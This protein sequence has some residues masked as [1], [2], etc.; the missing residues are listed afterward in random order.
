MDSI[1][2]ISTLNFKNFNVGNKYK[3]IFIGFILSLIFRV[4]I[5]TPILYYFVLIIA[6]GVYFSVFIIPKKLLIYP[7]VIII[8]TMPDLT[9]STNELDVYG[10]IE[11]ANLWQFSIGSFT[12]AVLIFFMLLVV[13]I[14]LLPIPK[15]LPY[16]KILFYFILI[17]PIVSIYNGFLQN[18]LARFV[19]DF[20]IV[21]FFC[22]GLIIFHCYFNQF[23]TELGKITI[24]FVF[25]ALGTFIIDLIKFIFK[26]DNQ[27]IEQSYYNLS[28]DSAKGLITIFLF[29]ALTKLLKGKKI[30]INLIVILIVIVLLF[31][32][33]TRWLLVTLILGVLLM[34]S[35]NGF[36]KL[37]KILAI[38]ALV[39]S[40]VVP[41]L[42]E[43]NPEPW[44][45]M[46]LRFGFVETLGA[47]SDITDLELARG[48]A[49]IN[50]VSTIAD[51]RAW[52][53]GLGYGSWYSD[54]YFPM[55]NLTTAAFDEESLKKGQYYRIHDFAFHF[56]FKFG[57]IGLYL[58]CGL[59]FSP[60]RDIWR[61]KANLFKNHFNQT[62]LL[63]YIGIMPMALT[64]MFTTGKGLLFSA[65]YIV[66]LKYWIECISSNFN[67]LKS[68]AL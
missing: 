57:I 66:T 14:R 25:L 26:S 41:I 33:Q 15:Q 67:L 38:I 10:L 31:S 13:M 17:L 1:L 56:L 64:F 28:M 58:Y 47:N 60:V 46:M 51:K 63:I 9:Q 2:K 32:Y 19:S 43:L 8:L 22:S 24:E 27:S 4:D 49:I 3:L 5:T 35:F 42:N 55:S 39:F 54:I 21:T 34:L 30:L 45:I 37:L 53:T 23:K 52:L 16:K 59:F 61:A 12:P 40:I 62:L 44:K 36:F 20:K 11:S 29:Y 18:S 68:D 65:L 48:S 7:I 6:L 50:S